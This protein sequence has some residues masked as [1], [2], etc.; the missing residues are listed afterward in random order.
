MRHVRI[1]NRTKIRRS[2]VVKVVD[3]T[4]G[5]SDPHEAALFHLEQFKRIMQDT[6]I[7]IESKD[8][9]AIKRSI[10]LIEKRLNSDE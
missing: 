8:L 1:P 3:N 5:P 2:E 10:T 9:A 6:G 7:E 4:A